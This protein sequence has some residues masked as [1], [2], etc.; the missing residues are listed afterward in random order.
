[1]GTNAK[2]ILMPDRTPYRP[3]SCSFYDELEL[4][5]LQQRLCLVHYRDEEGGEL[6]VQSRIRQLL[7][8]DGE[9]FLQLDTGEWVRLDRLIA[10][11]DKRLEHYC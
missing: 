10:I 1:M 8:R 4:A 5:A 11:D 6:R 2:G 7:T 9:E 3:I